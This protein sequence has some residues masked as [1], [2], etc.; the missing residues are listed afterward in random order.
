MSEN[1]K[2]NESRD[3]SMSKLNKTKRQS[4][5]MSEDTINDESRESPISK[6]KKTKSNRLGFFRIKPIA[7]LL[8]S[9]AEF[10]FVMELGE[11]VKHLLP[12][13]SEMILEAKDAQVKY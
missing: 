4:T 8:P 9:D 5:L 3:S 11:R 12:V 13:P 10:K 6:D 1:I 7:S 2:K